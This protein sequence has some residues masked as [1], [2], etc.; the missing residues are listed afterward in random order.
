MSFDFGLRPA[1]GRFPPH[2]FLIG[3]SILILSALISSLGFMSNLLAP[4]KPQQH[5]NLCFETRGQA[6]P[7][8]A[9]TASSANRSRSTPVGNSRYDSMKRSSSDFLNSVFPEGLYL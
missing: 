8:T 4:D 5:A 9:F 3:A 6:H 7:I 2:D 1:P